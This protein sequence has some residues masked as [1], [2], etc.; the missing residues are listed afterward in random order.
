M[1]SFGFRVRVQGVRV[2][3]MGAGGLVGLGL[4]RFWGFSETERD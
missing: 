2:D 3:V 4:C 1:E